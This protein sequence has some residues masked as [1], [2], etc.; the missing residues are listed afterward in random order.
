[1]RR[2]RRNDGGVDAAQL[3]NADPEAWLSPA[4]RIR[5]VELVDDARARWAVDRDAPT[6]L[7]KLAPV[8]R[9]P[10][11]IDDNRERAIALTEKLV[12]SYRRSL[13][14]WK[15][16]AATGLDGASVAAE[17]ALGHVSHPDED[18]PRWIAAGPL[19]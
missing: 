10:T 11:R 7:D 14:G 16:A 9:L 2:L 19:T 12:V 5:I 15:Y 4:E 8:A 3:R 13:A 6:E 1:M 18:H 17:F